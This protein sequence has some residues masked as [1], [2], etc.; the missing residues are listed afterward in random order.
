MKL[1]I[2]KSYFKTPYP[3]LSLNTSEDDIAPYIFDSQSE[4]LKS[5]LGKDFYD[6][7]LNLYNVEKA[8]SLV[9]VGATTAFQ[10]NAHGLSTGY[11]VSFIEFSGANASE[12][13]GREYQITVIDENSFSIN[14]NST[15]KVFTGGKIERILTDKYKSLKNVI[16]PFLIYDAYSRYLP[17]SSIKDT[18]SGTVQKVM[19]QSQ[20]I[21]PALM[22]RMVNQK[23]ASANFYK[24]EMI[25]FLN[26]NKEDYSF[27]T[28]EDESAVSKNSS[29]N[30]IAIFSKNRIN[31]N[32]SYNT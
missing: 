21:D 20:H 22:G 25:D 29:S 32:Q 4:S 31:Y 18:A 7:L 17:Y 15:G 2:N 8:I 12:L 9:I 13:N 1:L 11:F 14:F 16:E 6:D 23:A 10:V 19:Q 27:W 24:N 30:P 26:K 3:N 28:Y 5:V